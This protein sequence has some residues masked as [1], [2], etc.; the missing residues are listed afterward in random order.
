[1]CQYHSSKVGVGKDGDVISH[2]VFMSTSCDDV[3]GN[4]GMRSSIMQGR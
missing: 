1:M 2:H 3:A 4:T